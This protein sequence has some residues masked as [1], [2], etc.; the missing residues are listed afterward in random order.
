M[1]NRLSELFPIESIGPLIGGAL[2]W[3]ALNYLFIAPELI[4]P[5]LAEKYYAPAC[6]AAVAD[7]RQARASEVASLKQAFQERLQQTA[8]E[9]QRTLHAQTGNMF[10]MLFGGGRD[11][12][13]FMQKYGGQLDSWAGNMYAP[14]IQQRIQ[15]ERAA[16]ARKLAA[17]EQEARRGVIYHTPVQFCGC[18]VAE[19]MKERVD[20]AAYTAT[21]RL[22][23]PPAVRRLA[24][25]TMLHFTPA[26]GSVPVV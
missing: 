8:Q 2:L 7:G 11:G 13:A 3:F 14:A 16:F 25:G 1:E 6:L 10:G 23:S 4:G 9:L 20:M 17:Q 19:G 22:Y 24:D 21:L 26:C 15:E 5:R 12:T 18:V